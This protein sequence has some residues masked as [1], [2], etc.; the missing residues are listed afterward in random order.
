MT[1][2]VTAAGRG[3]S[4]TLFEQAPSLGGK[5]NFAD[6][7]PFKYPLAAYKNWLIRQLG[8]SGAEVR[9]NA[10]ARPEDV[11]RYDAVVAAVGSEPLIPAVPG[12]ERAI[13]AI[14]VYGREDALGGRIVVIGGGEVGLETALHLA[15]RGRALT[16]LEMRPGLAQDASKT[17]R[18]ELMVELRNEGARVSALTGA[19]CARIIDGAVFYEKGGAEHKISADSVILAVGMRALAARADSF[20]G[21]TEECAEVGDCVRARSVEWAVKEGYF[22]ALAL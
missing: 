2:A 6:H 14:D 4:V 3:H 21:L 17:H 5:L 11:R 16:L 20:M 10:E 13:S 9:L 12:V 8:K 19:V 1:A 15:K 7:A 18:D 22:A